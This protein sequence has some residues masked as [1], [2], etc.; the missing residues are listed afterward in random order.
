MTQ[1]RLAS[2]RAPSQQCNNTSAT[3]RRW[4]SA[5]ASRF[6]NPNGPGTSPRAGAFSG[7]RR[8]GR[9]WLDSR[10]ALATPIRLREDCDDQL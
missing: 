7:P 8:A 4:L 6:S 3:I 2:G 1:M 10:P 5:E 9:E